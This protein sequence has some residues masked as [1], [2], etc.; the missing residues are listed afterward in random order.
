MVFGNVAYQSPHTLDEFPPDMTRVFT[1][2][3]QLRLQKPVFQNRPDNEHEHKQ[4]RHNKGPMRPEQQG[5]SNSTKTPKSVARVAHYPIGTG[6]D[7][8]V[9][10]VSLNPDDS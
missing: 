6:V 7:N 9:T 8:L 1:I 4:A 3:W 10:A 5:N 2:A